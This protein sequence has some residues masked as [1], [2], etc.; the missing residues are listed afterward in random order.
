MGSGTMLNSTSGIPSNITLGEAIEGT[1]DVLVIGAGV[2]GATASILA[3]QSGLKVLLVESKS[4]PREK[5]CGGCLNARSVAML[6]RLQ[7]L[8]ALR[9]EGAVELNRFH[10]Q[11][12]SLGYCWNLPTMLSVRR[13]TLDSLLVER[14]K[15]VGVRYLDQTAATVDSTQATPACPLEVQ[16]KSTGSL[17]TT[18][19][20]LASQPVPRPHVATRAHCV[21]VAAGLTR[22]GLDSP[23]SWPSVVQADSRIGVQ[24]LIPA[25]RWDESNSID[26]SKSLHAPGVLHMLVGEHGYVGVCRT[27]GDTID[28]AAAIDPKRVSGKSGIADQVAATFRE[29]GFHAIPE[30]HTARWQSTP[31]LTRTTP[32]VAQNRIF[33]LGDSMGY[34]EPFTGEGMS[35]AFAGAFALAPLLQQALADRDFHTAMVHWNDWANHQR[36]FSQS[37]CHWVARQA[38]NTR[39]ARWVLRLCDWIPL[40]R[41]YLLRKATQ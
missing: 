28:V 36:R 32:I 31:H 37:V 38:R 16:L 1:W 19:E 14:A 22:S 10:V 27:D 35:W 13:S 33:L 15:C 40:A 12:G 24:C 25:S 21:V 2:A 4:F 41:H 8:D 11:L 18:G 17:V 9:D 20:E 34:V 29:C 6:D 7:V 23:S 3:A 39:R 30:L 5:V 26:D